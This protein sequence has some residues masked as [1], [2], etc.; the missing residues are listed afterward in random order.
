[1]SEDQVRDYY[2]SFGEREWDRLDRA[3]GV[4]EF[5]VNT[6]FLERFLPANGRVLDLGGGPGRYTEWLAGRGHQVVL[7]DLS[8]EQLDI[9][10]RRLSSP[11]V[12]EI[13]QVDARNLS[14]WNDES[15]DAAVVLGPS[16]TFLT[17]RIA[18]SS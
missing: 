15:F 14:R 16:T 5:L 8:P 2:A 17:K 18:R 9:A 1:M 11:L 3:E 13:V 7:A 4:I 10:T 12:E 6:H